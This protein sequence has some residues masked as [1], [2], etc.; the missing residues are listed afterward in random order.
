MRGESMTFLTSGNDLCDVLPEPSEKTCCSKVDVKHCGTESDDNKGGCC[1]EEEFTL[2]LELPF[3]ENVEQL[4][5][6]APFLISFIHTFFSLEFVDSSK[7]L[8]SINRFRPPPSRWGRDLLAFV[9][10]FRI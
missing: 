5:I 2:L 10:V 9:S 3:S 7:S 8:V 4:N 6:H 1:D